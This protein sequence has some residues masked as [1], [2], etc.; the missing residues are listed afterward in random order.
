MMKKTDKDLRAEMAQIASMLDALQDLLQNYR[1]SYVPTCGEVSF[2]GDGDAI[3]PGPPHDPFTRDEDFLSPVRVV[4]DAFCW[5]Y[6]NIE[7]SKAYTQPICQAL[8]NLYVFAN[9][10]ETA[11]GYVMDVTLYPAHWTVARNFAEL[12]AGRNGGIIPFEP[13]SER[14]FNKLEHVVDKC[15]AQITCEFFGGYHDIVK[16]MNGDLDALNVFDEGEDY[17]ADAPVG[18]S[19]EALASWPKSW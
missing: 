11:G 16:A 1:M 17:T 13:L 2:S 8:T 19:G 6:E 12:F 18:P 9:S 5:M 7:D 4:G 15:L 10:C 3:Y 14:C